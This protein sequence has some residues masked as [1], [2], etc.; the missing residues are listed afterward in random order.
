MTEGST[1]GGNVAKIRLR[2]LGRVRERALGLIGP[3]P[4]QK[5][6]VIDFMGNHRPK[7]ETGFNMY[8][9]YK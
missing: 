6:Q 1:S 3:C 4:D 5:N 9:R 7:Y 8:Y 2:A